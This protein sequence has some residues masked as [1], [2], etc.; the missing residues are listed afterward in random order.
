MDF[1]LTVL[2]YLFLGALQ[3]FTEPIPISS[4]GHVV[5]VQKL[6]GLEIEGLSFETFVNTASLLAVLLVF[7]EDIRR[8][9]QSTLAYITR[10]SAADSEQG[11][12]QKND[13]LFVIYLVLG[14]I[15]AGVIGV[16]FNDYIGEHL[17]GVHIVGY[18]LAVTAIALFV[19]R[20]MRGRKNDAQLSWKDALIVGFGQ[21]VALIPGISRSGATIVTAMLIGMKQE[22]ALRFSF[23]LYIPISLGGAILELPDL[24]A[25]EWTPVLI[26]SYAVAFIASF[27][28][29]FYALKWFINIMKNGK[30][31][32]FSA[33][34]LLL[35]LCILIF[36]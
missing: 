2:K 15:P 12:E 22:T 1:L 24:L 9:F 3:G 17:K 26:V 35:A 34:C 7:R 28:A 29:S 20:N 36:L 25:M 5:L 33:Y 23:L 14:T 21:A 10:Q 18:S 31:V 30:L 4:S 13:F 6:L 11:K 32:Y 27:V 8:L 19:I 16:L